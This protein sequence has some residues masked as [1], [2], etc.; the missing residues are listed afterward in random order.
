MSRESRNEEAEDDESREAAAENEIHDTSLV[1]YSL[2]HDVQ[3]VAV[4]PWHGLGRYR[5]R[6]VAT[7]NIEALLVAT[8]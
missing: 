3:S 6:G 4:E 8:G 2:P 1:E 5:P 7:P